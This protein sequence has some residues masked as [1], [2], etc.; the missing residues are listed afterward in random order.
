MSPRRIAR[1]RALQALFAYE[2]SG[3]DT[4]HVIKHVLHPAIGDDAEARLFAERLL[5]ET[6]KNREFADSIIVNHIKNWDIERLAVIDKIVLRMALTEFISFEDIPPKVT[7]NE[8]IDLAKGFSTEQSGLFV[9]GVLDAALQ[10]LKQEGKILKKGRGL[11]E[12]S[13][14]PAP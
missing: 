7:I 5:L 1:A 6:L 14:G 13:E 11:I 12:G 3:D 10:V 9:N 2:L 8:A 4:E